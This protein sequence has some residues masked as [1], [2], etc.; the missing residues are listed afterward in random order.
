VVG[1]E[2]GQNHAMSTRACNPEVGSTLEAV[3]CTESGVVSR[4]V[5]LQET[6]FHVAFLLVKQKGYHIVIHFGNYFPFNR[7]PLWSSSKSSWLQIQMSGFDSRRFKIF[8]EVVVLERCPLSLVST[9]EELLGKKSSGSG[10]ESQEYG[11]RGSVTL[12][13]WQLLSAGP[14]GIVRL[15]V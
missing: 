10:L 11:R 7:P 9:I 12:T 8:W 13:T 3:I 6:I 5:G 2:K 1:V 14:V 15:Q 4:V